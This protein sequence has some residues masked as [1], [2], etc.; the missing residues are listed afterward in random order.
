MSDLNSTKFHQTKQTKTAGNQKRFSGRYFILVGLI[1]ILGAAGLTCYNFWD[2]RRAGDASES[3]AEILVQ[4]VDENVKTGEVPLPVADTEDEPFREMATS[5]IDGHIYI[6]TVESPTLGMN[7]PVMQDWDLD[8]LKISPCRYTGSYYTDDLVICAHNYRK[9]F[10]PFRRL[11]V[12]DEIIFHTVDGQDFRYII[13]NIETIKPPEIEKM[14]AN[15]SNS[16]S[17][18]QWDLTLFTCT[19]GGQARWAIRCDRVE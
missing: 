4:K 3:V 2:D 13:S 5:E 18:N 9:H 6:G 10:S 14:I 8:S 17:N 7:L 15:T 19:V 16:D 11:P 12:G 1:C